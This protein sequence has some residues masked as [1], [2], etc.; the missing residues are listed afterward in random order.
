[1]AASRGQ[2][3]A[4]GVQ[5][6]VVKKGKCEIQAYSGWSGPEGEVHVLGG[7]VLAVPEGTA[8]RTDALAIAEYLMSKEVQSILAVQLAWPSIRGDAY[9]G[10]DPAL[11]PYWDAINE[12][13]SKT[14]A[15]PN[16]PYWPEV[17][18]ILG[19]AWEDVVINGMD[20]EQR[21]NI[22]AAEIEKAR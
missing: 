2:N 20:V 4:F 22:Y 7:D 5:E 16:V 10:V 19:R 3:W 6:I 15:R 12:A 13:M 18:Q 1:M 17:E 9:D 11:K 14:Q 8:N 21:L